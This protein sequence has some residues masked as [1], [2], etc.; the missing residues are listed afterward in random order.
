MSCACLCRQR[1]SPGIL[2]RGRRAG[3][4]QSDDRLHARL[5]AAARKAARTLRSRRSRCDDDPLDRA[6][7]AD[8]AY[9]PVARLASR[10]IDAIEQKRPVSPGFAEGYRVQELLDAAR[11]SHGRGAWLDA[12]PE[13]TP[14][15]SARILVTGGSG[16]I[17]SALVK[18]LVKAGHT[19]RV[20][21]DNSRGAPRR[22]EAVKNDIEFIGGDIRNAATVERAV[23]GMD[24][25]HHL[26]FVNGTEFFYSA[27]RAGARCRREGHDQ[28]DRRLPRHGRA[29]SDPRLK[30]RGLSDAAAGADRRDARR[31]WCRTCSNPRY[32]YGGGKLISELMAINYGRK[33]FDRVL[34]FRPHNV[35]GPDMGCEHVVPQFA[36]RLKKAR[37]APPER[38]G[39]VR[40]PGRRQADPQ[41]LPCR[42]PGARRRW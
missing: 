37:R 24:E 9:P 41:L 18:A 14:K 11:R 13:R 20:L 2:R 17:G 22:L 39:A 12:E 21:D 26:A 35:Y 36:L 23:R 28:R 1:A 42:R 19:V 32:S 5:H 8:G 34:I 25:V 4:G 15:M 30:L 10:F 6:I 3:A 38:Q 40:D 7:L 27:A 16:F 31:C 29:Q 33:H